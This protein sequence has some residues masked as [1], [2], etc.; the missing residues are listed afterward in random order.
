MKDDSEQNDIDHELRTY[1]KMPTF[2]FTSFVIHLKKFRPFCHAIAKRGFE[3][4]HTGKGGRL[5]LNRGEP[6]CWHR[7]SRREVLCGLAGVIGT[8]AWAKTGSESFSLGPTP[9]FLD[10]DMTLLS[11]LERALGMRSGCRPIRSCRKGLAICSSAPVGRPPLE[12]RRYYASFTYQAQSWKK[13]RRVVAKSSG[14]RVSFT[15]AWGSS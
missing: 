9:V 2:N 5:T 7:I 6:R 15:R 10:N 12:V 4:V 8:P 14:I 13:W 1:L 11:L 3:S